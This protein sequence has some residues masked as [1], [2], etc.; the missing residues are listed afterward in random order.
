M[1]SI[2]ARLL[3]QGETFQQVANILNVVLD[4]RFG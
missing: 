1:P 2:T 4:A 3:R